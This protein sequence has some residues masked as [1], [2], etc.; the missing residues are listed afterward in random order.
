MFKNADI[1]KAV[2]FAQE[3]LEDTYVDMDKSLPIYGEGPEF[4][5]VT[6]FMRYE[7]SIPIVRHHDNPILDTI[8]YEVEYL[9]GHKAS[10]SENTI[11]ENLF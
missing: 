4:S 8:V 1:T 11:S 2:D 7:N 3:V 10:L 6:K 9:D 5:K